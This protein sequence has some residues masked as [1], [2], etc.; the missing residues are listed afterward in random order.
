MPLGLSGVPGVWLVEVVAGSRRLR[1]RIS[2]GGLRLWQRPSVA[3]QV[4]QVMDE[5]WRPVQVGCAVLQHAVES[6]YRPSCHATAHREC[7]HCGE[8]FVNSLP[9]V[10]RKS[11]ISAQQQVW[12]WLHTVQGVRVWCDGKEYTGGTGAGSSEVLLPYARQEDS[13]ALVVAAGL[14]S[15][16]AGGGKEAVVLVEGFR[17]ESDS[18]TMDGRWSEATEYQVCVGSVHAAEQHQP[19]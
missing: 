18:S 19:A 11:V 12:R 1:A 6:P 7:L 15:S 16:L 13:T 10:A 9:L 3:G 14:S 17:S 4:L 2:K 5:A 8:Q